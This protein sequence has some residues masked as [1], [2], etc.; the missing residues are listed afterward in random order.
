MA[1]S[2]FHG[3]EDQKTSRKEVALRVAQKIFKT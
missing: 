1:F 3:Y 2:G